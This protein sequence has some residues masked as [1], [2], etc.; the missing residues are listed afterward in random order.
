MQTVYKKLAILDEYLVD[1]L[2]MLTP[3]HHLDDRL[4][5]SHVNRRRR[6][7]AI[8]DVHSWMA[9]PRMSEQLYMT[10]VTET[11]VEDKLSKKSFWRSLFGD[12]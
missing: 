2:W 4:S 8:N 1:H 10:Q 9:Q 5:L 7:G 12:P 11:Y 6:V 3:D